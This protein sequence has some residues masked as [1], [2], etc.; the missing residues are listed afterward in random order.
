MP[1][2]IEVRDFSDFAVTKSLIEP[3]GRPVRFKNAYVNAGRAAEDASFNISHQLAS[4]AS[5]LFLWMYRQE[6]NVSTLGKDGLGQKIDKTCQMG[7]FFRTVQKS[8]PQRQVQ[9]SRDLFP[10]L[11]ESRVAVGEYF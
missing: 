2:T 4:N 10:V 5:P 8:A 6:S 3:L 9:C 1:T 7:F 11:F